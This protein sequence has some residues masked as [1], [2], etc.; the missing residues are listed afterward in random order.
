VKRNSRK[1]NEKRIKVDWLGWV[2]LGCHGIRFV[3]W[4]GSVR[5]VPRHVRFGALTR[6]KILKW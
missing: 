1:E 6:L 5:F 4:F 3:P 2:G